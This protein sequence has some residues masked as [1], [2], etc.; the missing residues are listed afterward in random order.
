MILRIL[1]R[2][3]IEHY[4]GRCTYDVQTVKW[5]QE[6]IGLSANEEGGGPQISKFREHHGWLAAQ[7][8]QISSWIA[9]PSHARFAAII[10][11]YL[12][13]CTYDIQSVKQGQ[14]RICLFADK[15]GEDP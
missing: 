1:E 13:R 8:H 15:E 14:E 9:S 4:L 7:A 3:I 11:H 2:Q 12:G 5:G 10:E 6:R